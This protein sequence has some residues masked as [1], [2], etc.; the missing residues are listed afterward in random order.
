MKNTCFYLIAVAMFIFQGCDASSENNA[1]LASV[2]SDGDRPDDFAE[3]AEHAT[4][5]VVH[6]NAYGEGGGERHPL[7]ELFGD[8]EGGPEQQQQPPGQGPG[9]Q[10][11]DPNL[12]GSGSGVIISEEGHIVTSLHIIAEAES[13][14]VTLNDKRVY[15]ATVEGTD[16]LTDLALIKIEEQDLPI[17]EFAD[18]DELQ[19]GEW[20]IAVGNPFNLTSTV[21]AGIVSAKGRNLNILEGNGNRSIESFIQTDAAVNPGNS[22]GALV[23]T[24]GD[25]VGI[26][27]AIASPTGAFAGYSFAVPGNMVRKVVDDIMEYGEV[28]RGLLGVMIQDLNAQLADERDIENLNGVYVHEVNPGSAADDAGLQDGD[29]IVSLEDSEVNSPAEVQEIIGMKRPDEEVTVEYRRDGETR[30]TT[31][32]LQGGTDS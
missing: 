8:P 1:H 10:D 16:P 27:A 5:A 31:A 22:G 25:L 20:V 7:E 3:A 28:R 26:N 24:N 30:S 18:S 2:F 32:R 14:Q 29:I 19:V 12:L 17:L 11:Q 15:D 4:P 13:I 6:I 23:N 9:Q 21:T